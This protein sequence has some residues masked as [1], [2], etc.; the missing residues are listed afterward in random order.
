MMRRA[1]QL[2][3]CGLGLVS[4]N[5][6]VGAVITAPDGRIIGE[7]YH[8]RYGGPHAEVNAIASVAEADREL[9]TQSTIYVTLEP[10][11]HYGKT[12]PCA[13]LLIDTGIPRVVVGTLDPFSEVSGRG[14]RMLLDA[15][16]DVITGVLENECRSLNAKFFTAH[17]LGRPFVTLKWA[18]SADGYMDITRTPDMSPARMSTS[19]TQTL[20][21]G[22]RSVHDGIIVGAKTMRM[23]RPRLDTRFWPYGATPHPVVLGNCNAD[24]LRAKPVIFQN[25]ESI[26]TILQT[27]YSRERMI[28]VLVEGGANVLNQFLDRR[29]WDVAR[30]EVTSETFGK[31]GAVPAPAIG[32]IPQRVDTIDGNTV[33][34]YVNNGLVDVKNI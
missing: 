7:G 16:I 14:I 21:H 26:E 31:S 20:V 30:I 6:M 10:C 23:D 3:R 1:L 28:S 8:R 24:N 5:P 18:Q 15:G 25:K 2:A 33:Y 27:L 9:L 29:L 13:R 34:W 22:L 32:R 11:S 12:P 17:T 19:L 4:P